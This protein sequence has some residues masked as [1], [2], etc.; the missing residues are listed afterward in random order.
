MWR[1]EG[2]RWSYQQEW[3]SQCQGEGEV[4]LNISQL[5]FP[6]LTPTLR[7]TRFPVM[8]PE[9]QA[10]VLWVVYTQPVGQISSWIRT[11]YS[12]EYCYLG[13]LGLFQKLPLSNFLLWPSDLD[14]EI[15]NCRKKARLIYCVLIYTTSFQD[16]SGDFQVQGCHIQL[17]Q[18]YTAQF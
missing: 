8:L 11:L 9:N 6:P 7:L 12:Y 4:D 15:A 17:C 1:R 14:F 18:L 16:S 2:N 13:A 5:H 3:S 10:K